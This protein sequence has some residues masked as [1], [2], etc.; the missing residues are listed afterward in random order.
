MLEFGGVKYFLDGSAG[1]R[2]AWMS[3]PYLDQPDNFGVKMLPE[4]EIEALCLEAHGSA[5][6]WFAMR[7]V[8]PPSAS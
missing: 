2:T 4:A 5:S 3:E 6:S 8:M 1:G 7:S